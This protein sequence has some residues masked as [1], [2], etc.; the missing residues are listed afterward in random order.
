MIHKTK[1]RYLYTVLFWAA[2]KSGFDVVSKNLLMRL[3]K[4]ALNEVGDAD[5][6]HAEKMQR[7]EEDN[8]GLIIFE[9]TVESDKP[10]SN[11]DTDIMPVIRK[12]YPNARYIMMIPVEKK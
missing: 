8:D 11:P 10:I 9:E 6:H 5:P 3:F 4:E 2:P 12:R 7:F 1:I